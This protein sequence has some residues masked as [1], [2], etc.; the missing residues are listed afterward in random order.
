MTE[1]GSSVHLREGSVGLPGLISQS[2]SGV[3]PEIAA[4][5]V[6]GSVAVFAGATVPAAFLIAIIATLALSFIVGFLARSGSEAGGMYS[7]VERVLGRR[8]GHFVGWS[9]LVVYI[10]SVA[11]LGILTGVVLQAFFGNVAPSV[12]FFTDSWI[13]TAII[14]AALALA[15]SYVGIRIAVGVLLTVSAVGCGCILLMAIVILAR[16]GAHGIVW[17]ALVPGGVS[18]V[19]FSRFIL[20][21]GVAFIT[22]VGFESVTNLGEEARNPSRNLPTAVV[23]TVAILGV[24][25]LTV[26][27]AVVSGYGTGSKGVSALE[28]DSFLSVS[29]MSNRYLAPWYGDLL[30]MVIAVASFTS[31][32]AAANG[33]SRMLYSWGRD[34][35]LPRAF[36]RLSP[37]FQTPQIGTAA[38]AGVSAL[39]FVGAALW[40]GGKPAGGIV[41]F[42][43]VVLLATVCGILAYLAIIVAGTVACVRQHASLWITAVAPLVGVIVLGVALYSQ[44]IPTPA[45]PY[46][47]APYTALGVIA[48]GT[49][50]LVVGGERRRRRADDSAETMPP[51]RGPLADNE[52]PG[53]P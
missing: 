40:Q 14:V 51:T 7:L 13:P 3:G 5:A 48:L 33:A 21:V 20:G 16:G 45:A 25:F 47:Y 9:L 23:A 24:F 50:W 22:Y 41:A 29:T 43:W 17:S 49:T 44:F 38:L 19:R 28:T 1:P 11:G 6:A 4:V 52:A 18:G 53:T 12:H 8:A 15:F 36:A 2:V 35:S 30:L 32:L 26:T 34:G 10:N 39:Y 46:T 37:R 27:L 31:A 42:S